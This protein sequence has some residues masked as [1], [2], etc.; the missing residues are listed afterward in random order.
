MEKYMAFWKRGWWAWLMVLCVN[1]CFG[2]ALVPLAMV[3]HGHKTAY[4]LSVIGTWGVIG[5]PLMGWWFEKFAASSSRLIPPS[6]E[7]GSV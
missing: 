3:F 4:W 6:R 7:G 5:A 1:V 2:L